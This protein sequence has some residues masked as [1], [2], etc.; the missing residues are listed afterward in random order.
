MAAADMID[1]MITR[2]CRR[3][4]MSSILAASLAI[5]A[6]A[7][8]YRGWSGVLPP[9]QW[10]PAL[11]GQSADGVSALVFA[12]A[13]L[14]RF[15]LSLL[16]GAALA[17]SGVIFQSVLRNP[18]AEPAT[19][20]S[21]AGAQLAL[22]I[23][24]LQAPW[25]L[26]LDRGGVALAGAAIATLLTFGL[27]WQRAF[28]PISVILIGLV[29]SLGGGAL[30]NIFAVLHH[31]QLRGIF[32]WSTGS[33]AQN[34]WGTV[35]ALFPRLA[36]AAACVLLLIRPLTVMGLDDGN[37]HSLGLPLLGSR[38]LALAVA[39]ALG[40]F[41]VSAV[42]VIG[43]IGLAAPALAR[44]SGARRLRDQLVWA[45]LTGAVLLW[46]ADQLAQTI[47][48]SSGGL[49]TGTVTAVLGAPLL[50]WML[51]KSARPASFGTSGSVGHEPIARPWWLIGALG[52]LLLLSLW[53]ALDIGQGPSGWHVSAPGELLELWRW[54]WPRMTAALSAGAML[55]VAGSLIQ[56]LAANPM[57]SPEVLGVSSGAA[58]GV[59]LL[60]C[61][62]G[63]SG[64]NSQ[65][66]AAAMGAAAVLGLLLLAGRRSAF[67]PERLLLAGIAVGPFEHRSPEL[68][69]EPARDQR[70]AEKAIAVHPVAPLRQRVAVIAVL[71]RYGHQPCQFA[72]GFD[73]DELDAARG[74]EGLKGGKQIPAFE[75][76]VGRRCP[77]RQRIPA[78]HF[79]DPGKIAPFT[80]LRVDR[81]RAR[82]REA[83]GACGSGELE[84]LARQAR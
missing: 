56:R 75:E 15:I 22:T 21:A 49:P 3:R 31:E 80:S 23:A 40:A 77:L 81:R 7:L 55:A 47:G 63:I 38:L 39:V 28:S 33:L 19:L 57:A 60:V 76:R 50:L 58:L 9:G 44:I 37:A 2:P 78:H 12:Y 53:P 79:L 69:L 66:I 27:S 20:G 71:E 5:S 16:C 68:L 13:L 30:S 25:L 43:F 4:A 14:P 72:V 59:I 35:L 83:L 46:L 51:P 8:T 45:P 64:R 32:I 11:A 1:A 26:E 10:L 17:L 62:A 65:L 67:P 54:R 24:S 70:H 73:A 74:I 6:V 84:R 52:V 42:G 61:V 82:E 18:L 29:V 41:T 36:V 34:G 48:R